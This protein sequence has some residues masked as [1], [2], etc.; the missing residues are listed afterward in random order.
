MLEP[1]ND[2]EHL[3]RNLRNIYQDK[4]IAQAI[5]PKR[6]PDVEEWP[7]IQLD[8][9]DILMPP[10]WQ[11]MRQMRAKGWQLDRHKLDELDRAGD[12]RVIPSPARRGDDGPWV[13]ETVPL[14]AAEP[15]VSSAGGGSLQRGAADRQR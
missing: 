8:R 15:A 5:Q 14:H 11:L 12:Y 4:A 6:T 13:F 10:Y 9:E 2:E 3:K 7:P 1:E